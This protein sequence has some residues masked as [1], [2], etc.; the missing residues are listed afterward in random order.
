MKTHGQAIN[1]LTKTLIGAREEARQVYHQIQSYELHPPTNIFRTQG[2]VDVN[3]H[4]NR[5]SFT[6]REVL[7]VLHSSDSSFPF[8][9]TGIRRIKWWWAGKND[10]M[11]EWLVFR[12]FSSRTEQRWQLMKSANKTRET[13]ETRDKQ[14]QQGS[15]K[16]TVSICRSIKVMNR[17]T[18]EWIEKDATLIIRLIQI[19]WFIERDERKKYR[20]G[21]QKIE[22]KSDK[23]QEKANEQRLIHE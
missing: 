15:T 12:L 2:V 8:S 19:Q 7:Q 5:S 13:P 3:V 21:K 22:I 20:G 6:R 16:F 23:V 18:D 9:F 1:R 14:C 4:W 17:N 11:T 10:I